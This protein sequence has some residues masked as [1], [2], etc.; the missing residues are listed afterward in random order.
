[1]QS[2]P[3]ER[4]AKFG[5]DNPMERPAQ[6]AEIAPTFV[7]LASDEP[8]FVNGEVLGVTGGRPLA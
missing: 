2:Y 1:M 5:A 4:I 6:P 3:K 8:R 7:F